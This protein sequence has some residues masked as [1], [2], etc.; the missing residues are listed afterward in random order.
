MKRKRF[1]LMTHLQDKHCTTEIMKQ[2]LARR[3]KAAQSTKVETSASSSSAAAQHP[4]YAP[5]AALHAIKRHALEFVNPKELQDDNEGP[6][7]KSIRLTASLIL[8]NL[9]IYSSHCK[10]YLKS[11][12]SH[13]AN[14]AL[15]NVESSRTIAQVLYD[16]NDGST[17]R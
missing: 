1:S 14:V 12:E 3:K 5:D 16:M 7:T 4:G 17:H 11:Y 2:A 10:R 13:L 8:R 15:S 9:V 6:V